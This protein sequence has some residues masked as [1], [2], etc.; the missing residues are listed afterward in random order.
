MAGPHVDLFADVTITAS[1]SQPI[2]FLVPLRSDQPASR[3]VKERFFG[4]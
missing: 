1:A 2:A 4:T 3:S